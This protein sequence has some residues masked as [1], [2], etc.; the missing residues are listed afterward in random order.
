MKSK[1]KKNPYATFSI[2][3]I[4]GTNVKNS[5]IKSSKITSTTD[6]RTKAGK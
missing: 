6:M 3:P 4:K 1:E 2:L 5:G